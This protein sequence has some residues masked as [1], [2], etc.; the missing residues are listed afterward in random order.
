M[1]PATGALWA[2]HDK[3]PGDRWRLFSTVAKT[4]SAERVLYPGSYI[5]IAP[6]FVFPTVT[7]VDYNKPAKAFFADVEGV[8][9]IIA[10]HDGAPADPSVTFIAGDY[11]EPLDLDD[12][13]FDLLVSLYGGFISDHCTRH[14]EV[15]G[16]LLVNPSHGDAALASID[17]R[18]QL[19][20]AVLEREGG[21]RID[22]DDLD[23]YL[24]PKK[25]VI[26]TRESL[27]ERGR[28]IAYTKPAFAYLFTRIA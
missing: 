17:S 21:Y 11:T 5:D 10:G 27:L 22:E 25:S 9:E 20:G 19:A 6:S 28:G 2:K 24:V 1:R 23:S 12:Q 26:I 18:Y 16:T 14:L 3:H 7:Y 8:L 4:V 15:G 13:S